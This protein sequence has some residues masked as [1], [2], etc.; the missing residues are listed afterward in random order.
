MNVNYSIVPS[1]KNVYSWISLDPKAAFFADKIVEMWTEDVLMR[2]PS[3]VEGFEVVAE[4]TCREDCAGER[5]RHLRDMESHLQ[6]KTLPDIAGTRPFY[7]CILTP[8]RLSST[9]AHE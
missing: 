7:L 2:I 9:H 5:L 4:V 1:R 6:G 3:Y 8:L